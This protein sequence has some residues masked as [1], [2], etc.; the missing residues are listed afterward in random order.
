MLIIFSNI[1]RV[2]SFNKG[3]AVIKIKQY[4]ICISKH[5]IFFEFFPNTD[6]V[7]MLEQAYSFLELT[8]LCNL[9]SSAET[10]G[11]GLIIIVIPVNNLMHS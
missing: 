9:P 4:N 11:T 7:S 8:T 5:C 10:S 3:T 2:N 1:I 6:D